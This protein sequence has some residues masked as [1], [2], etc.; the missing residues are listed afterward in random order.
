[1]WLR[2]LTRAGILDNCFSQIQSPDCFSFSG[3]RLEAAGFQVQYQSP[4]TLNADFVYYFKGFW[5]QRNDQAKD[6]FQTYFESCYIYIF[7]QF[8]TLLLNRF[9]RT[10]SDD[11]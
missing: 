2:H 7:L 6:S 10:K 9:L 11:N 5:M 3:E 4:V 8:H 1:M